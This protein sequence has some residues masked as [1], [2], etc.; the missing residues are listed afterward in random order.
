MAASTASNFFS[1]TASTKPIEEFVRSD[2]LR[3]AIRALAK[4]SE[5]AKFLENILDGTDFNSQAQAPFNSS[6]LNG[7]V[8]LRPVP[9]SLSLQLSFWTWIPEW[10]F[11]CFIYYIIRQQRGWWLS[12][13][14]GLHGMQRRLLRVRFPRLP[15]RPRQHPHE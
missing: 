7:Y 8:A 3:S 5:V 13:R 11:K 14:L 2:S 9:S 12:A 10:H 6:P 4:K 15:R 1:L